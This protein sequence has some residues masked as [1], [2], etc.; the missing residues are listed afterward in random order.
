MDWK[1]S[2]RVGPCVLRPGGVVIRMSWRVTNWISWFF[3]FR[4]HYR[5]AKLEARGI[6]DLLTAGMTSSWTTCETR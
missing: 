2:S 4:A 1:L 5:I 3:S 6:D